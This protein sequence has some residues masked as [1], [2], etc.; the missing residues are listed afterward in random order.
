M[1]KCMH[2]ELYPESSSF[3]TTHKSNAIIPDAHGNILWHIVEDTLTSDMEKYQIVAAFQKAMDAWNRYLAPIQLVSSGNARRSPIR[4][5]FAKNGDRILPAKFEPGVLA[6]AYFPRRHSLGIHSDMYFNDSQQ[7][8]ELHKPGHIN[9][10]KVAVHELGH[11]LG[12]H[13]NNIIEDIMYPTY[14]PNDEVNITEDTQNAID[15]LYGDYKKKFAPKP[16]PTPPPVNPEP[17]P[18]PTPNPEP[19]GEEKLWNEVIDVLKPLF[20]KYADLQTQTGQTIGELFKPII[21]R[22]PDFNNPLYPKGKESWLIGGST[23]DRPTS[24]EESCY[25]NYV[26]NEPK[27]N[28]NNR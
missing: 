9:L 7:W 1:S 8:S 12:I 3:R 13:H 5:F 21:P 17:V 16:K 2:D 4:I 18:E 6:Y 23:R 26:E 28:K 24:L 14:Q 15:H 27:S 25:A 22:E 20:K 10:F 11:A 19:D